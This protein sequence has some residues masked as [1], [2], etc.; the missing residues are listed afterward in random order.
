M[1]RKCADLNY[2]NAQFVCSR[3]AN[4]SNVVSLYPWLGILKLTK[5]DKWLRSCFLHTLGL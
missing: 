2:N 4:Y 1:L 3:H 5:R